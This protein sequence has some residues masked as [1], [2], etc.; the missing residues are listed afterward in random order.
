MDELSRQ[1]GPFKRTLEMRAKVVQIPGRSCALSSVVEHYLHTVGVTG[2]NP[3]AR[4]I[5]SLPSIS[6]FLRFPFPWHGTCKGE[7]Y[8]NHFVS[9][10]VGCRRWNS[11]LSVS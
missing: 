3:V 7:L 6:V 8:V 4:T 2:S 11:L 5:F 10:R 1:N 9:G